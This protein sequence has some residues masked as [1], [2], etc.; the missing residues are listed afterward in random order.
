[1]YNRFGDRIFAV[2]GDIFPT[3][4]ELSRNQLDFSIS[5]KFDKVSYKLGISN[6]LDDQYRFYQD[7]NKDNKINKSEDDAIFTNK[8]GALFNFN[9]TYKF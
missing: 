4:Y 3:I 2:G 7:S 1:M 8:I 9:V 5:K 6:L